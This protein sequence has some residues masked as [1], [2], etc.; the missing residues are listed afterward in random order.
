[1]A[2]QKLGAHLEL[3]PSVF[4]GTTTLRVLGVADVN[5]KLIAA[6]PSPARLTGSARR[7]AACRRRSPTREF[8]SP[9]FAVGG[10]TSIRNFE[11]GNGY[12][13]YA[14][15]DRI[16]LGGGIDRNFFDILRLSG[17]LDGAFNLGNGRS[18]SSARSRAACS[19]TGS[20]AARPP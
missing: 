4:I 7:S 16:A 12:F 6:L 1:M 15:P 10:T 9:V 2:L 19:T 13:V 20:A 3:D 8:T 11:L 14:Y 5:G 18:T 17:H